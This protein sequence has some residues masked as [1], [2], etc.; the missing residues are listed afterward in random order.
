MSAIS[1]IKVS[2][3]RRVAGTGVL[4]ISYVLGIFYIVQFGVRD[5]FYQVKIVDYINNSV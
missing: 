2:K 4:F 1:K 5:M 3:S